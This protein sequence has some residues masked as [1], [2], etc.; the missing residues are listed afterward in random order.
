MPSCTLSAAWAGSIKSASLS[1]TGNVFLTIPTLS[2]IGQGHGV[3]SPSHAAWL[4]LMKT[5]SLSI[6]T[7]LRF[8][9]RADIARAT[10]FKGAWRTEAVC[11][12]RGIII[13]KESRH[14]NTPVVPI[15][16]CN[17]RPLV[18]SFI[19]YGAVYGAMCM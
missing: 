15:M 7:R 3:G 18:A 1:E 13:I 12:D 11:L 16:L 4:R 9:K 8:V 17:Q 10:G 6:L 2:S 19:V 5:H 14:V